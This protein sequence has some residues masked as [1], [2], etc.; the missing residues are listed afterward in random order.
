MKIFYCF[1][2]ML[3]V[4][5]A[6]S[7]Q[8]SF[9][10]LDELLDYAQT[11]S[12][13]VQSFDTKIAQAKKAK[14]AAVLGIIDLNTNNFFSYTDNTRLPVSLFPAETFGGQPGTFRQIQTGVQYV[15]NLNVYGEIKL[16]NFSGYENLKLAKINLESTAIDKQINLKQL[17]ENIASSYYNIVNLQA[18]IASTKENLAAADTLLQISKRKFDKGIAKLQELNDAKANV[19]TAQENIH[20][21]QFLLK[22]YELSLKILCDIPEDE[23]IEIKAVSIQN[24]SSESPKIVFN[25]LKSR[26][27][28]LKERYALANYRQNL[29]AQLP[30]LFLFASNVNQ[31][32]NTQFKFF[33]NNVNW[34]NS[35]YIGLKLTFNLLPSAKS[36]SQIYNTKYEY[37]LAKQEAK[38]A[39]IKAKLEFEQLEVDY[40]KAVS[41]SKA[42]Q[43]IFDLKRDSF[44]KNKAL[45]AEGII[46]L[47]QTINSYNAMVNANYNA[48]TAYLNVQLA[49][50]KININNKM[51]SI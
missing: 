12:I 30:T 39:D 34:I 26:S 16:L 32:F 20:Q 22:Q 29:K 35:N 24:T 33:D 8:I 23:A 37:H 1:L 41:Q 40:Q 4:S 51:K 9:G 31:Q 15:S 36:V 5:I 18:Q 46:A 25:N 17:F 45:Y 11:K 44:L 48:I 50:S 14:L 6:S 42:N 7:A 27:G 49:I 38:H 10:N 47:D 28:M 43:E 13:S 3:L 19:L 2:I 21:L